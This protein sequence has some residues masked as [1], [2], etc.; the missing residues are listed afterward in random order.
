ME[1]SILDAARGFINYFF[2]RFL[3][4]EKNMKEKYTK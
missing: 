1:E 3:Y 2:E 4:I